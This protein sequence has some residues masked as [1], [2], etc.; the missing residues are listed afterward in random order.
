M[1]HLGSA[2]RDSKSGAMSERSN[3]HPLV[4]AVVCTLGNLTGS[5]ECSL[6]DPKCVESGRKL[7]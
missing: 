2:V 4:E 7:S 1:M 5:C 6:A 3:L